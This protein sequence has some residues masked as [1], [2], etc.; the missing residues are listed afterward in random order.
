M[1]REPLKRLCS[2]K[3]REYDAPH[4]KTRHWEEQI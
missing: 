3:K 1:A 4:L 2:A